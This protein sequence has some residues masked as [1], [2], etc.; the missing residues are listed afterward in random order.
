M[1]HLRFLALILIGLLLGLLAV[2]AAGDAGLPAEPAPS[3][4]TI[5]SITLKAPYH[6]C[7]IKSH[8]GVQEFIREHAKAYPLLTVA[9]YSQPPNF[10][11]WYS[12]GSSE[13]V[14]VKHK[15]AGEL[16]QVLSERGVH[17]GTVTVEVPVIDPPCMDEL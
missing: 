11:F 2:P 3:T 13:T 16:I 6:T 7:V 12:D 14:V 8:P 5:I 4:K 1:L 15:S 9:P 10:V 17:P